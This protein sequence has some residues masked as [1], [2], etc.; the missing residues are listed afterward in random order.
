MSTVRKSSS[1]RIAALFMVGMLALGALALAGCGGTKE[2][3]GGPN[4]TGAAETV[5]AAAEN[6]K[7]EVT[8]ALKASGATFNLAYI[9]AV[10]GPAA[11]QITVTGPIKL[12][13][14]TSAKT[15]VFAKGKDGKWVIVST[16]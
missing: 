3:P 9:S 8:D 13:D 7:T 5:K 1:V 2:S 15:V 6:V 10:E 4:G 16:Q 12:K 11:G 14:G